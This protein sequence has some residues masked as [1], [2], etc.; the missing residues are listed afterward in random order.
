MTTPPYFWK[1]G[2]VV[3]LI[4][5]FLVMLIVL[6]SIQYTKPIL[7]LACNPVYLPIVVHRVISVFQMLSFREGK[8]EANS[9]FKVIMK[10]G[11]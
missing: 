7:L 4:V 2:N 11:L 6:R 3:V 1:N 9:G 8:E 5:L 10:V